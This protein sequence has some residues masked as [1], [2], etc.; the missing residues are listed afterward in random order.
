VKIDLSQVGSEIVDLT[1]G[2]PGMPSGMLSNWARKF[3]EVLVLDGI[4]ARA[5]IDV[6]R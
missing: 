3:E 2:I 6:F 5:I 1:R 4:P